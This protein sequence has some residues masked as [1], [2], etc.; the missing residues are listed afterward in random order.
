MIKQMLVCFPF[1]TRWKPFLSDSFPHTVVQTHRRMMVWSLRKKKNQTPKYRLW[2]NKS[3]FH[4]KAG[5]HEGAS[6]DQSYR[7]AP[8]W[9]FLP[10]LPCAPLALRQT[11]DQHQ[12]GTV[13]FLF[14]SN[15]APSR[16]GTWVS[17]VTASQT[18]LE[19]NTFANLY[20]GICILGF[21]SPI[22]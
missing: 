14:T 2:G 1:E 11:C 22:K 13:H 7:R 6:R 15:P 10:R 3:Q 18:Q 5:L 17:S 16:K 4:G 19:L 12:T 8:S 20:P 21:C 9:P